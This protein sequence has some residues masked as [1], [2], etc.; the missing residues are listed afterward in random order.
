MN[1]LMLASLTVLLAGATALPAVAE[2]GGRRAAG[3]SSSQ[4]VGNKGP[5]RE[6]REEAREQHEE[7]RREPQDGRQDARADHRDRGDQPQARV[8][9]RDPR[10][11]ARQE[12]ARENRQDVRPGAAN[13]ESLARQRWLAQQQPRDSDRNGA[14]DRNRDDDR[15]AYD[16]NR[17]YSRDDDQGEDRDGDRYSSRQVRDEWRNDRHD[18]RGEPRRGN[19]YY[20]RYQD[21][22]WSGYNWYP[23]YRY[24]APARYYYPSGYGPYRWQVGYRMP[25]GFYHQQAYVLDWRMY[26]LPPPPY[27]Y[28]WLRVDRDVVLVSMATGYVRDV[29]YGL[30]Y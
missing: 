27:G 8:D 11:D 12:L 16:R 30:F 5:A 25:Y 3:E 9:Q 7:D 20:T 13:A 6:E 26:R 22:R 24:R 21:A 23:Q 28:Q 18:W 1:K 2:D 29:L 10:Q 15:R 17:D 19:N 4:G 14:Y